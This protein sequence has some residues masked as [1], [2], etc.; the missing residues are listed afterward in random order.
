[1]PFKGLNSYGNYIFFILDT[2]GQ[3][4]VP[5]FFVASGYFFA[6]KVDSDNV[7]T[8][9]TKVAR[10]LGSLYLFGVLWSVA[11]LASVRLILDKPVV[12]P[13]VQ[14]ILTN[15]MIL[16]MLY[17][18]DSVSTHLWF[19]TAL[20]YSLVFISLFVSIGK[21]RYIL[22]IAAVFHVLGILTQNYPMIFEISRPTRDALFFGF[23]Y[24]ALGFHIRST[25][26]TVDEERSRLYLGAFCVLLVAQLLEQYAIAYLIRGVDLGNI[27]WT[28]YTISTTLLV[29]SLFVYALSNPDLGKG[30]ILPELGEYTVGIFIL[31]VPLVHAFSSLSTII[32]SQFG[33]D[34][35]TTI[36]WQIAIVPV[37]YVLS[38]GLY[39]L[40]AKL[41]IIELGGSHI[42]W[43][44]YLRTRLQTTSSDREV[45][46][47]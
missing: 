26:W 3:F 22:P 35:T 13:I 43:L 44:G 32:T 23:F 41:R 45:T 14:N 19:L 15:N 37:V 9:V 36:V 30:T 46:A 1:M 2:I 24:V 11:L 25:D 7:R 17:Y 18:G 34:P 33:I 47:D 5:F 31:H 38:L 20:I 12:A 21:S 28:E 27:Y 40:M 16:D 4:D 6:K 42:P 39:L 8:Y 10:K 29:F